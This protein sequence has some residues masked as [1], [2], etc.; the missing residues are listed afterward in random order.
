MGFS[1]SAE[2]LARGAVGADADDLEDSGG[3][4]AGEAPQL[5]P[6][7]LGMLMPVNRLSTF[8]TSFLATGASSAACFLV[9]SSA[10]RKHRHQPI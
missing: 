5:L 9:D 4:G 2:V 3:E 10:D 8:C 6:S 1:L 7:A